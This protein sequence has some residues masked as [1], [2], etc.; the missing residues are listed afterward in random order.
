MRAWLP[1]VGVTILAV[2]VSTS[3]GTGALEKGRP[4][5]DFEVE[6]VAQPG[7]LVHLSDFK[8]K[9]VLIDFWAT[10]CGP[11]RELAT[12]IDQFKKKYGG[13]GLEVVAVSD[14]SRAAVELYK[15]EENHSYPLYLDSL[16]QANGVYKGDYIP[17]VYVVD[18][19]GTLVYSEDGGTTGDIEK[20]I[21]KGLSSKA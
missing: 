5:P 2:L 20:A 12:T 17:R 6:S 13:Q 1:F 19:Q 14:E 8:G 10:W 16:D 21:Q 3:C 11:C 9:V 7:K 4:A 15:K 18:R